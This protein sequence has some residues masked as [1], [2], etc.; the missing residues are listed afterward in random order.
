SQNNEP[1]AGQ[2]FRP[3][4]IAR[5]PC[6]VVMSSAVQLHD[7]LRARTIKIQHVTVER[8]LAGGI[9]SLRNFGSLSVAKKYAQAQS[10]SFSAIE[11]DP[12]LILT[13]NVSSEKGFVDA[14]P[15]SSP[16]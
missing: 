8:M 13:V 6:T 12:R 1:M 4:S 7:E 11:L 9:C 3:P 16:R 5:L 10:P 15:H 2:E 14:S